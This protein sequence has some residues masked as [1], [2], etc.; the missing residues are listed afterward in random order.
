M[1]RRRRKHRSH[2][3]NPRK[4]PRA[5]VGNPRKHR[6]AK[7]RVHRRRYVASRGPGEHRKMRTYRLRNKHGK[8][9]GHVRGWR[10]RR[11]NGSSGLMV[12]AIALGVGVLASVAASYLIDQTLSTQSTT[13][14]DGVL[15]SLAGLAAWFIPSPA[16]VGGVVTGLLLVPAAKMIYA[17]IPSLATPN[18]TNPEGVGA[19]SSQTAASSTSSTSGIAS[20]P[21]TLTGLGAMRAL[22]SAN[23]WGALHRPGRIGALHSGQDLMAMASR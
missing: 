9:L 12:G 6:A 15:V 11:V 23:Q 13:V 10:A 5:R 1:A 2:R 17:A 18:S 21:G 7:R 4:N 22:Q 8:R 20:V 19:T 14:Q 3:K 16:I